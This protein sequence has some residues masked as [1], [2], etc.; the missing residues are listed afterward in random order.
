LRIKKTIR[1]GRSKSDRSW[2]YGLNPVLEAI[3]SGRHIHAVYLSSRRFEKKHEIE[4]EAKKRKIPVKTIEPKFF[5]IQFNKGHQGIAAEVSFKEYVQVEELFA[6]SQVKNEIPLLLIL[7][8][9]EDPRNFG[10]ILRVAEAAGV[11]GVIIQEYR[12]VALGAEVSKV[13]A[14]AVE[15]VPV[16]LVVNIKHPIYKMKERGI[17][18]VGTDANTEKSIWDIDLALPLAVVVGSEGKGLRRTVSNVCDSL[19]RIPMMGKINSLNVSVASGILLFEI[20]RQRMQKIEQKLE[21]TG[22]K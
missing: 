20:M 17:T 1:A 12:S 3:R 22:N 10:A 9:V 13:S 7:D 15:Y 11:H 4:K 21:K 16:S 14:G 19:V 2:I 8:C 6:F 18:I 5:D